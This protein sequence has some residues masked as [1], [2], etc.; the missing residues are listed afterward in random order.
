[1]RK[2]VFFVTLVFLYYSSIAG[3]MYQDLEVAPADS[4]RYEFFKADAKFLE[5]I[6]REPIEN[7]KKL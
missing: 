5:I 3:A 4:N 2:I 6:Q 7:I 1:M